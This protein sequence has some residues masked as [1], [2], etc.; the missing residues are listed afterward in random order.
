MQ[1][2]WETQ[3]QPLEGEDPMEEEMA[4]HSSVFLFK[5]L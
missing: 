1:E 5:I 4:M 2:T 3:V